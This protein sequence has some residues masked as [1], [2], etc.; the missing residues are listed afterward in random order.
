MCS[1]FP[2]EF[3]IQG[4]I[5]KD[6]NWWAQII[7]VF[8]IIC[9]VLSFQ[10]KSNKALLVVQAIADALFG[11]QFILLG[12]YTGCFGMII[13]VLRNIFIYFKERNNFF[14][15]KGWKY[16]FIVLILISTIFTWD[17]IKSILPFIA[18]AGATYIYFENNARKYRTVNLFCASPCW[19]IYDLLVGSYA[20]ALNEIITM[21]SITVSIIRFGWKSLGDNEFK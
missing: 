11:I 17:G 7:G 15:F 10:I 3:I 19:L 14:S 5:M 1:E 9:F 21:I 6:I 12:G 13:V 2:Y 8:G 16:V 4:I 18:C 20:G